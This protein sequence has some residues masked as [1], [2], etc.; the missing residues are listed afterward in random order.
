MKHSAFF[1]FFSTIMA[2]LM[3]ALG[4]LAAAAEPGPAAA[5]PREIWLVDR[6]GMSLGEQALVV[7]L[8]GLVAKR[9]PVIWLDHD[10]MTRV[11]L[12][13]LRAEK[14]KVI[15]VSSAWELLKLFRSHVQ[16]MV[17]FKFGTES[18][19]AASS[20]CG[21]LGCVAVEESI[22]PEA[23][24]AGLELKADARALS[25]REVFEKYRKQF[26]PRLAVEQ[27]PVA[28]LHL[29]DFAIKNNLFTYF[30]D[31]RDLRKKVARELGPAALVYGWGGSEYDWIS[32][33][34]QAGAAGI[35]ANWCLNLSVMG[36]LPAPLEPRPHRYPAKIKEG[37]RIVAFVMS[38]GD[39]IQWMTG[40]FNENPGFWASPLRGK[41]NMTWEMAPCLAHD[42]PRALRYFYRG[43]SRGEFLDDFVCGPSGSGYTFPAQRP[44][45][46]A[47]GRQTGAA[48]KASGMSIVSLLDAKGDMSQAAELLDRPE[49]MGIIYKD[50]APYNRFAGKIVWKNGKPCVSYTHLL[51]EPK[52]KNSPEGVAKA[53]AAM[54]AAPDRDAGSYALINVHAW[55]WKSIGGP[56][57]A[58]KKTIDLLPKGTRVVTAEE[59]IILLRN[60]F[61][62]PVPN[63][64]EK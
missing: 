16:G 55:S 64:E 1:R 18:I 60:N 40:G 50:Y 58:V 28:W 15:P 56:M 49:I 43:A 54:P 3:L 27:D 26:A 34:S 14:T 47:F 19:N 23:R 61:G 59:L 42:A 32:D 36:G 39:N 4:G 11:L 57:A 48:L 45:L 62:K 20:L 46:S 7:S 21:P 24:K 13:E 6:K 8:Q 10:G 41:F 63:P 29:R 17:V 44:D 52:P 53:I 9:E 12:D 37:E 38:D 30:G 35:A 51:W 25:E 5:A 2:G 31:D 33:L 22:L